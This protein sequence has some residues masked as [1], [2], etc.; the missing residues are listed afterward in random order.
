VIDGSQLS[1]C[2]ALEALRGHD[3][4]WVT[5][6]EDARQVL[7]DKRIDFIL[8]GIEAAD[9]RAAPPSEMVPEIIRL[10][11]RHN[12]PLCLVANSDENGVYGN[13]GH[14]ALR[15]ASAENIAETVQ[16]LRKIG[17]DSAALLGKMRCT[18]TYVMPESEK[19][20]SIWLKALEMLQTMCISAAIAPK[21]VKSNGRRLTPLPRK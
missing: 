21:P 12:S 9:K 20:P 19:S 4:T 5:S 6:L 8:S 15:A 16:N 2:N 3:V 17:A 10:A 18:C 11:H 13:N 1:G 7:A 14:V